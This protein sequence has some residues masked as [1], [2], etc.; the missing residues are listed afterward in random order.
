LVTD[1]DVW[2]K[3]WEHEVSEPGQAALVRAAQRGDKAAL[4]TLVVRHRPM[5]VAVC[6]GALGDAD[7]AEDAAQEAVLLALVSLDRLRQADRFGP[8]L[9]GIG[10]N[11]CRRWLRERSRVSWSWEAVAGGRVGG[12]PIPS[13]GPVELTEAAEDARMVRAAVARLPAG[14]RVAVTLHYLAGLTQAET[15]AQ[16]GIS[17]GAVRVRLHKARVRLRERL[18]P[19]WKEE[20]MAVEEAT[21][22]VQMRVSDVRRGAASGEEPERHVV[23]LEEVDGTRRLLIWIGPFEATA[24]AMSLQGA[25]LPRPSSLQFAAGLLAVA[26]GALR[27]VRVSRLVEG[28]FYAEAVVDGAAGQGGVD[29]RPSDALTLAL[30]TDAPIRV[31]S[32]II[33]EAASTPFAWRLEEL[34]AGV[35]EIVTERQAD[36]KRAR[37]VFATARDQGT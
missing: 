1:A 17:V 29:A 26:R 27:E 14:Q 33:D 18:E 36:W 28:T 4:A 20:R 13:P 31:D 7:L 21:G 8:W 34:P 12:W 24:L 3:D 22:W 35:A 30:L 6:R 9:A 2:V 32:A 11:V 16:A 37:A 23:V 25:E 10:L 5:L 15:A 19:W